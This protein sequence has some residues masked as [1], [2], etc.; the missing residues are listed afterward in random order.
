VATGT[1]RDEALAEIRE[2]IAFHLEGLAA[3]AEPAPR[4]NTSVTTV[5]V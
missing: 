5:T 4:A 1:T 2:A 3:D